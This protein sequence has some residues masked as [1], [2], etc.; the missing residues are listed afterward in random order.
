MHVR[1]AATW[2]AQFPTFLSRGLAHE[3]IG[4]IEEEGPGSDSVEGRQACRSWICGGE[5]G[6]MRGLPPWLTRITVQ[7]PIMTGIHQIRFD[8]GRMIAGRH[9]PLH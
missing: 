3:V 1:T 4:R 5:D 7:M 6:N 2:K 8:T 9:G